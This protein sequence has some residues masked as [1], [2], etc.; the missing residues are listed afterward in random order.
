MQHLSKVAV[1][2]IVKLNENGAAV[3]YVV[4]H[5][6]RPSNSYDTSCDGT[7]VLRQD[8]AENQ[9]WDSGDSNVLES[10]DVHS[11]LNNTWINRY[12]T[13][14]RNAIK[15]VKIPYRQ[16]GG[17][18]GTDLN[19]ANGLSCKIFL[20]S[21][22]EVGFTN[23]ES[24]HFPNDG[25]KLDYFISGN[26]F[27]AQKKRIAKLNGSDARW[28]LRS[29][30][31]GNG[32]Y[33][34]SC[35]F[36]GHHYEWDASDSYGV[37]P[38][39][40]LPSILLVSDD[41]SIKTNTAPTAPGN[42]TIPGQANKG[43]NVAVSWSASTDQDGNLSGYTLQ[44]S[45]NGG[46]FTQVYQGANTSYTDTAPTNAD[47]LQYRV[48]AYDTEGATSGW[49]TSD[50]FPVYGVPALTVPSLAMQGQSIAVNWTSIEGADSYTLE[51]KSS[52]DADWTQVYSGTALTFSETVGTWTTVQYRV[53]AVFDGTPGGWA[54]SAEIP[55]V[56]ASALVISGQD[57]DLGTL[58]NDVPYSISTDTGN[59]ITATITANGAVIFSGNV[60]NSVAG[61]IPVLD[62]INGAGTIVIEASVTAS[63]GP[64]SAVRTWTYTKTMMTFPNAGS[65]AELTKDG[66]VMW[67]ETLAEA[68][69][70]P[71]GKTLDQVMGFPCQIY[72]GSYVG[73]GTFGESNPNEITAP[74]EPKFALIANANDDKAGQRSW[75]YIGQEKPTN[76]WREG[77]SVVWYSITNATEQCNSDGTKY[78]YIVMG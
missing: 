75:M 7:W 59:Q 51:R 68:V 17:S 21:G 72:T 31:T 8:I 60:G 19:G 16:N 71:G 73:T 12:D 62:L 50:S 34:W 61:V 27:S 20:L 37:R 56:S 1:E 11:Y 78:L 69:R 48:Q 49:T 36:G 41:G 54:T 40:V 64:V 28:W 77:N 44:R 45:V 26:T 13:D 24:P 38:A 58:V 30:Y 67:P 47:T 74:F 10:S 42:L 43:G 57:G 70:I 39:L 6:G 23:N 25:A 46:G 52:A 15:Q 9:V 32:V 14:I 4:V 18:S 63:S 35:G 29:P 53:Q 5:Q 3:N 22:R 33:V 66:K 76:I 55:V 65:I 2:S